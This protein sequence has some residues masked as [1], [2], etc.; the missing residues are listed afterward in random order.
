MSASPVYVY[1]KVSNT[2]GPN[3]RGRGA[4]KFQKVNKRAGVGI[5]GQLNLTV[6][7]AP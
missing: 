5:K 3:K 2:G 4:E 7:S 1:S 6:P